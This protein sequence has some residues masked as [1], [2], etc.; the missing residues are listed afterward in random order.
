MTFIMT[1]QPQLR[2]V[3]EREYIVLIYHIVNQWEGR[4]VFPNAGMLR[5]TQHGK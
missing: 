2:Q 4:V 1:F 5:F 3:T